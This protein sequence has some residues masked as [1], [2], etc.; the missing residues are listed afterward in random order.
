MMTLKYGLFQFTGQAN[1][2]PP[3]YPIVLLTPALLR[4]H[5]Y[6]LRS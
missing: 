6:I 1:R 5:V 4:Q 3:S 2:R